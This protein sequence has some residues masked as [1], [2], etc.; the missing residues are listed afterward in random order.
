MLSLEDS[1][2]ST[3]LEFT[4]LAVTGASSESSPSD[5]YTETG[6][7]PK[8]NSEAWSTSSWESIKRS[9]RPTTWIKHV[10]NE[11]KHA[12]FR[13]GSISADQ[14]FQNSNNFSER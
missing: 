1:F 14:P 2:P 13:V 5:G 9:W 10:Q 6:K 4:R 7:S 3:P 11:N 8:E 12:Q